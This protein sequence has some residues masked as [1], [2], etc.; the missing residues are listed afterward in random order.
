VGKGLPLY[1][2]YAAATGGSC[3]PLPFR[4]TESVKREAK[5][6]KKLLT[7]QWKRDIIGES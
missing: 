7:M 1:I 2:F 5:N 4:I 3:G 6:L